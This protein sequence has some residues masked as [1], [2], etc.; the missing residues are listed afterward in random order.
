M[1][2]GTPTADVAGRK[3]IAGQGEWIPTTGSIAS[4]AASSSRAALD[5]SLA[6][7]LDA[8]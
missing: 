3:G 2:R 6:A 7:S 1:K 4:S 5:R 8:S